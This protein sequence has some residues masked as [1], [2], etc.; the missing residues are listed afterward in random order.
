MEV[1]ILFEVGA[2]CLIPLTGVPKRHAT[3][4]ME[5]VKINKRELMNIAVSMASD[6][7]PGSHDRMSYTQ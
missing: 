1:C 7:P 3:A 6:D 2:V 4:T 5:P